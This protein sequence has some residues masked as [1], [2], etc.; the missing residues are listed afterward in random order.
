MEDRRMKGRS[1]EEWHKYVHYISFYIH[2][3]RAGKR[4]RG[5]GEER[6]R[7]RERGEREQKGREEKET[8]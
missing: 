5:E 2:R 3:E 8:G 4:E 6:E 1:V 7:E